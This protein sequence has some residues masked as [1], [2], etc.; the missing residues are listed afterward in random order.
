MSTLKTVQREFNEFVKDHVLTVLAD[1]DEVGRQIRC[2][3]PG[4]CIY[5]WDIV[6]WP[7]YLT[8]TGDLGHFVFRSQDDMLVDFFNGPINPQY[9]LE[10]CV[11]WDSPLRVV[12]AE[13]VRYMAV[14]AMEALA[15]EGELTDKLNEAWTQAVATAES[16]EGSA[17]FDNT[18]DDLQ[19][20]GVDMSDCDIAG[21]STHALRALCAIRWTREQYLAQGGSS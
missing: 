12:S 11:A 8:I 16:N 10:K 4:T 21:H 19:R 7:G 5:G 2:R 15:D 14:D 18:Y 20:A 9:W 17:S 6:T 1:G 13:R 3:K